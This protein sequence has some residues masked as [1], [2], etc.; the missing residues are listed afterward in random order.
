M[1][2]FR[3]RYRRIYL[4]SVEFS[5][6]HRIGAL[7]TRTSYLLIKNGIEWYLGVGTYQRKSNEKY[8]LYRS[9]FATDSETF[10]NKFPQNS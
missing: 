6:E 5:I 2:K 1:A 10:K 8:K 9:V 7:D 3:G 4:E